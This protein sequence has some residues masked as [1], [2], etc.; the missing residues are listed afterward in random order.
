MEQ[1]KHRALL[2]SLKRFDKPLESYVESLFEV[3]QD[4]KDS[5]DLLD[6]VWNEDTDAFL[7]L[8][9]LYGCSMIEI[10]QTATHFVNDYAFNDP[11]FSKPRRADMMPFFK[12]DML[13]LENQLP[14]LVLQKLIAVQV[15]DYTVIKE[16]NILTS[17]WLLILTIINLIKILRENEW[18]YMHI[19]MYI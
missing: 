6:P 17:F 14:M 10:L 15:G 19:K 1:H 16:S 3:V 13:M 12:C 5:Y 8:M 7:Q 18:T 4:L 9:V 11:I 2:H